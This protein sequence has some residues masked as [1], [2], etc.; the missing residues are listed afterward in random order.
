MSWVAVSDRL[1]DDDL[2]VLVATSECDEP[3]WLGW[4]DEEGWHSVDAVPLKVTHW[5]P[6]PEAPRS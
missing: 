4:H 6:I 5:M 2:T 3:V 1:P